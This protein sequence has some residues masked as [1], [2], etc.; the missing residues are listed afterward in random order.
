[1][2]SWRAAV[3][4]RFSH[5]AKEAQWAWLKERALLLALWEGPPDLVHQVRRCVLDLKRGSEARL[6][7]VVRE[8]FPA[9]WVVDR[10]GAQLSGGIDCR[11]LNQGTVR[12]R[13][14]LKVSIG[15]TALPY[16]EGAGLAFRAHPRDRE[17]KRLTLREYGP[18][19]PAAYPAADWLVLA[20]APL[21]GPIE[22]F[23]VKPVDPDP[24]LEPLLD[25]AAWE[26]TAD[27]LRVMLGDRTLARMVNAFQLRV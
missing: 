27:A 22:A 1:M 21:G 11:I 17:P 4:P 6:L 8:A 12:G 16:A 26:G 23:A 18:A 14:E 10:V 2:V 3:N 7:R 24:V 20:Y 9:G 5:A 15:R 13:V 19:G 25:A